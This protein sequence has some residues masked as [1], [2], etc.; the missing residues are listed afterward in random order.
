MDRQWSSCLHLFERWTPPPSPL[1]II[2]DGSA[3]AIITWYDYR[4]G[5]NYDIYAQ[6]VDSAGVVQWTVDGVAICTN[7]GNQEWPQIISDGSAGA[8]IT[9]HDDRSGNW[10]IYAQR[11]D[12]VGAVQWTAD[13]VAICTAPGDQYSPQMISDGSGEPSSS[14]TTTAAAAAGMSTPRERTPTARS[15]G[16]PTA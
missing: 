4:S 5:S 13:G 12:S 9:W 11:V 3:G 1:Q 10:D 6:R 2:S 14:G 16:L 7:P 15:S 8:I